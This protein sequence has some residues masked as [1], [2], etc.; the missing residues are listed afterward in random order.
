AISLRRGIKPRNPQQVTKSFETCGSTVHTTTD[1]NDTEWFRRGE[2]L[3]AKKAEAFQSKKIESSNANISKTPTKKHMTG[4]KS[5]L[6]KDVEQPGPK[7]VFEDDST[8]ITK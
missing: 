2:A 1:Q 4:V 5:Y 6:H 7:V 3:Q 8:C